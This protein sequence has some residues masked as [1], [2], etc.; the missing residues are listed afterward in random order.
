MTN[1]IALLL[2][3]TLLGCSDVSDTKQSENKPKKENNIKLPEHQHHSKTNKPI[4]KDL[5]SKIQELVESK[6][7]N[8]RLLEI[9]IGDLN[10]DA[11]QDIIAI[12][13]RTCLNQEG[14]DTTKTICR[15]VLFFIN[16][17]L[18]QFKLEAYND[19]IIDCSTCGG[20]GVGDP[21][22]SIRI[23]NGSIT[24]ESFYGACDKTTIFK[25]YKYD[26]RKKNWYLK[27]IRTESYSC[28]QEPVQGE[29]KINKS[30][31]TIDDF[32]IVSFS[33]NPY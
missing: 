6:F 23:Q 1:Q 13:T 7:K 11:H 33:E 14:T 22:Q 32:G 25:V 26:L 17:G 3:L 29:T 4:E 31:E 19:N 27:E 5:K 10:T 12:T 24:F 16:T 30:I 20:G 8:S 2:V 21:Y 15:K 18:D 9:I 28:N